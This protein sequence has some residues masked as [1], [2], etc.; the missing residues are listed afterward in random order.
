MLS[1][2]EHALPS[3]LIVR[4]LL[5]A[6]LQTVRPAGAGR[7]SAIPGPAGATISPGFPN[8]VNI[9]IDIYIYIIYMIIYIY[10]YYTYIYIYYIYIINHDMATVQTPSDSFRLQ[11]AFL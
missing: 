4:H 10:I 2:A 7:L 6:N 11:A 5:R 3:E 9:Y 1:S 8:L